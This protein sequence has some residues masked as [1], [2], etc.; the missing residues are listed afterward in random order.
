MV[1]EANW[2][3]FCLFGISLLF[4]DGMLCLD[5]AKLQFLDRAMRLIASQ[6]A[7][8]VLLINLSFFCLGVGSYCL[9]FCLMR[10][11]L[12]IFLHLL[13][14]LTC[15]QQG[16]ACFITTGLIMWTLQSHNIFFCTVIVNI[17]LSTCKLV[18]GQISRHIEHVYKTLHLIA[19]AW[20][21]IILES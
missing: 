4:P 18:V 16:Y 17:G 11:F 14:C 8:Q 9:D 3:V 10:C 21:V 2:R 7:A 6:L 20:E 5:W 19:L 15:K 13:F 12:K 1:S